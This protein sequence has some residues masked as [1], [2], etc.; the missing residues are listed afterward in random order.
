MGD[1]EKRTLLFNLF[2]SVEFVIDG[3]TTFC[4]ERSNIGLFDCDHEH[5]SCIRICM[6]QRFGKMNSYFMHQKLLIS[7]LLNW[8]LHDV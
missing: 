4:Q 5:R 1:Y 7:G 6:N 8:V 2:A 3:L